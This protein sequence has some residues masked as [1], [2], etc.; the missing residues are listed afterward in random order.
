MRATVCISVT[1]M[2]GP[3]P[4]VR[5]ITFQEAQAKLTDIKNKKWEASEAMVN[6]Q[7]E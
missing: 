7:W 4:V 5:T 6:N 1:E 3:W 2:E